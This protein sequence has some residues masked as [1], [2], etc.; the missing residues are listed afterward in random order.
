MYR[1]RTENLVTAVARLRRPGT[2]LFWF[3]DGCGK[4]GPT[5]RRAKSA[6]GTTAAFAGHR[7]FHAVGIGFA[8]RSF[9]V[10]GPQRHRRERAISH[11]IT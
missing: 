7:T 1:S 3:L 6:T 9:L 11:R 5:H 10:A 8:E 4:P 2:R